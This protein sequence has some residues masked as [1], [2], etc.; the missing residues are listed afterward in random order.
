M[1][2]NFC[3][4]VL[5]LA[6]IAALGG[7]A[8]VAPRPDSRGVD[9]LLVERGAQP[10]SPSTYEDV[11]ADGPLVTELPAQ[12]MTADSAVQIAM[13][14][15]PRLQQ[16]YARLGLAR[17]EV[18]EA[19][20]ISNPRFSISR[21]RP[22]SGPGSQLT[23]ALAMPIVDLLL[24][25]ARARLANADY[26]RARLDIAAAILGVANDV[27]SAWYAYVGAQQVADMRTAVAEAAGLSAELAKRFYDAGNISELQ[28]K[29]E[30]AAASEA[31]IEAGKSRAEALRARLA[32]NI[33][34]GLSGQTSEWKTADRLPQPV[35]REDDPVELHSL[36]RRNNLDLLA[37]RHELAVANSVLASTRHW[38]WLGGSDIGY[39]R[40]REVDGTRIQGPT[41]ALELP[42][43]NQGQARLARAEAMVAQAKARVAL[44][45]LGADNAVRLGAERVRI[46]RQVV[47]AHRDALIPQRESIVARSQDEQNFMLIGVFELLQAKAK[48]FDAYQGYLEAVRD[49]WLARVELARAVGQKLPSDADT[50][51]QTPSVQEIIT[52]ATTGDKPATEHEN[53]SGDQ[54]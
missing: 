13:L 2:T 26:E 34:V 53:H 3:R 6:V 36:A 25:P 39:E 4:A 5:A 19:V 45:E 43:F 10:M 32:L 41:L 1:D 15:S 37:A 8:G 21:L 12:P 27:R 51:V 14:H 18:L 16:E 35:A 47:V 50:P 42:I 46:L 52:P 40:E 33:I 11:G 31:R 44:A 49:Y 20:Q 17:A 54:P 7:C 29:Q 38:R 23:T 30:Q 48:E 9:A 24:L 22:Q 28:L